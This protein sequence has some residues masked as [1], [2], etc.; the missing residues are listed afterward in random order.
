MGTLPAPSCHQVHVYLLSA[1]HRD[2]PPPTSA[3][4][5]APTFLAL[6]PA[7]ADPP[8]LVACVVSCP[9]Q[10][11]QTQL[12]PPESG[13]MRGNLHPTDPEEGASLGALGRFLFSAWRVA[14][15]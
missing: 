9:F 11:R 14:P 15:R 12:V 5:T 4:P 7:V 3:P 8:S 1:Y 6:V 13:K 2:A 10:R